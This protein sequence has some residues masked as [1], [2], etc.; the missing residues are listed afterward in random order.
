MSIIAERTMLVSLTISQFTGWKR[1]KKG[2]KAVAR[3]YEV[4]EKIGNYN[5]TIISRD[6]LA[7]IQA[8]AMRIRQYHWEMTLPWLDDGM[9]LLPT[10]LYFDYIAKMSEFKSE[11]TNLVNEFIVAYPELIEEAKKN[12]KALFNP[13]DYPHPEDLRNKFAFTFNLL[14]A[15]DANDFRCKMEDEA[16]EEIKEKLTTQ[17]NDAHMIAVRDLWQRVSDVVGRMIDRLS[18]DKPRFGESM[19]SDMEALCGI[20]SKLNYMRD[21]DLDFVTRKMEDRL[22]KHSKEVLRD[23]AEIR[24]EVVDAAK[25]IQQD[26]ERLS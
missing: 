3:A 4:D 10:D 9:R 26:I 7:V 2:T 1:D 12:Q 6:K 13:H 23:N 20:M 5:K 18:K 24:R 16:I 8:L 19:L 11:F 22:L 15:P 21:P 25:E 14:P 17:I